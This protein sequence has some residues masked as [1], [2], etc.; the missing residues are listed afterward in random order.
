MLDEI[1]LRFRSLSGLD[2]PAHRFPR[3]RFLIGGA[4]I[5]ANHG[6]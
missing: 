5:D 2:Q 6:G 1:F 3:Q 4:P